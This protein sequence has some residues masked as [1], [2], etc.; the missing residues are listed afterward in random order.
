[1]GP[2][3][4]R[5]ETGFPGAPGPMGPQGKMGVNGEPGQ[6]GTPGLPGPQG[7]K[8]DVSQ[9]PISGRFKNVNLPFIYLRL[10]ISLFYI[11]D[12]KMRIN[13]DT[14]I[15]FVLYF[16]V[17]EYKLLVNRVEVSVTYTASKG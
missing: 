14:F 17:T 15:Y 9:F 16:A 10:C 12:N 7:E 11:Y 5:G 3:G 8:G 6:P 4:E 13:V 1:M 2:K